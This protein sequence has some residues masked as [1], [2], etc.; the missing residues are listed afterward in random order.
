[1]S[2]HYGDNTSLQQYTL[3]NYSLLGVT[4]GREVGVTGG[5]EVGVTGGREVG[6]T[7]GREVPMVTKHHYSNTLYTI[8]YC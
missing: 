3:H 6:V 1:M 8:T 7:G 5:R 4:D 2:N